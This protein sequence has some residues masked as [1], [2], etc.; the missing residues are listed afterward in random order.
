MRASAI[1]GVFYIN[2][3]KAYTSVFRQLIWPQE[4]SALVV[5]VTI[6]PGATI[7]LPHLPHVLARQLPPPIASM[8]TAWS[9][10]TWM[11]VPDWQCGR[12]Q[13]SSPILPG[14]HWPDLEC[15]FEELAVAICSPSTTN[16]TLNHHCST[17]LN[18]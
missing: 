16:P 11:R 14:R 2:L 9:R 6:H 7:S 5:T 8:L 10:T 17:H 12:E 4:P 1:F 13:V 15:M 3:E 18:W